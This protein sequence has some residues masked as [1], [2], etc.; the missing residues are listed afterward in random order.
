MRQGIYDRN[1][2]PFAYLE[3]DSVYDLDGAQI[4]YRR[5][6]AIYSLDG[7]KMWTIEGDGLYAQGQN[8]GYLGSPTAHDE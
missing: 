6:Q 8:I 4:A 5:D 7:E 1:G 2:E 3:G